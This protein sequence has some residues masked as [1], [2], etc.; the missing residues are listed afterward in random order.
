MSALLTT[1]SLRGALA[2][3]AERLT[4][5]D[6]PDPGACAEACLALFDLREALDDLP[7]DRWGRA[8]IAATPAVRSALRAIVEDART[9]SRYDRWLAA[10]ALA[11]AEPPGSN[12][13]R[14]EPPGG[15]GRFDRSASARDVHPPTTRP[16]AW[17]VT[18]SSRPS[19][20]TVKVSV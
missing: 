6:G 15:P 20:V 16:L 7:T 19:T 10:E 3:Q 9:F 13:K 2:A 12:A 1:A 8:R 4:A 5:C 14:P 18:G 11:S 17:K